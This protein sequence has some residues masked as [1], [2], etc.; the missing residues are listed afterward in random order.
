M[1]I[2]YKD[3]FDT[4]TITRNQLNEMINAQEKGIS[5]L[6]ANQSNAATIAAGFA[7]VAVTILALVFFKRTAVGVG[8]GI[9]SL[10]LTGT[11]N[12]KQQIKAQADY[13]KIDLLSTFRTMTNLGA[14]SV[15]MDLAYIEV[16]E[17]STLATHVTFVQGLAINY[18]TL[19]D[20]TK[21]TS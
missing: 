21:V 2:S 19:P 20:G 5:Y 11:S 17:Q 12:M 7:G 14:S 18:Y 8:S 1:A 15:T 10:V 13:G 3:K 4:V 9:S 16:Y 6:S